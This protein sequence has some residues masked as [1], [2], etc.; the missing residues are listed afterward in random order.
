MANSDDNQLSRRNFLTVASGALVGSSLL[1]ADWANPVTAAAA[2]M[3]EPTTDFKTGEVQANGLKFRYVEAGD[4]P[5]ALCFHGFPDSPWTYRYLM[6][7]LADAGYRAVAPYMR[8]YAP[9]EIPATG[10][11]RTRDLANDVAGLRGA[12]GG[13]GDSVLI[14][15]DWGAVAAWG[16]ASL[17]PAGW[18][19]CVIMNIPPLALIAT[20]MFEYPAIKR[21]FYWWF[22]QM[23]ISDQIVAKD[24][25]AFIEGLWKDWSPG[26]DPRNEL[27]HAKDCVRDPR[28]LRAALGY[29]RAFFNPERFATPPT[30]AEQAEVWGKPITQRCLYLHGSQDGLFPLD[31]QTLQ[32]VQPFMGPGS[33]VAMID[34]VGHFML[35]EDPREVNS[36]ILTFLSS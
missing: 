16:G 20:F 10:S 22:F 3:A 17:E 28:N 25:F 26:F 4:G 36:R 29:Y 14:A 7:A 15:H 32:E 13:D 2:P 5:L 1:G 35:V 33:E 8:G 24:D 9:T 27:S 34:G 30:A 6:T 23:Q 21:E 18:R 11:Y 12:L 31:A 19:R